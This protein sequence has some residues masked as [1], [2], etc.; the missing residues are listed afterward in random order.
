VVV[1]GPDAGRHHALGEQPFLI[2]RRAGAN[3]VVAEP[4][5]SA[6]HCEIRA[7]PGRDSL[8]VTDLH[9]TNGSFLDGRRLHER[10]LWF[11]GGLLQVGSLVLRHEFQPRD[12]VEAT[13]E[14]ERDLDRAGRYV[15]SLLP[16]PI[17]SGPVRAE[18][19]FKP[20][21][22]LGGDA[23]G[24][25]ALDQHRF[26][27]YVIDVCGHGAGAAMHTVS[28]LNVLRQRTLP[29]TDFGRPAEVLHRLN[30]TFRM[31]D[32]G[33]LYFTIWY[34]V[35]DARDRSLA[36]AGAGHHPAVLRH[37]DNSLQ[38]LATRNPMIG[39]LDE[40]SY[41]QASTAVPEGARLY[42]FSDG[43]FEIVDRQGR[44]WG[45]D[46]FMPLLAEAAVSGLSE[47]ER[48]YRRIADASSRPALDDDFSVITVTFLS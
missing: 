12:L 37:A 22:R 31:D 48:L 45:L 19:V 29:E 4:E 26:A 23:F 7:L 3:L 33:G 47:P 10:G 5:V 30:S 16:P 13:L 2:G 20:S 18:W 25:Q 1:K 14:A 24:Y 38:R 28:V 43:A 39:V 6:S 46:D 32:H 8:L 42:V 35:F 15:L 9:S 34:G 17:E 21:A 40:A 44:N 11:P 27:G 36:Y 41:Q